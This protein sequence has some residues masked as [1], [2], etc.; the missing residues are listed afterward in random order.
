MILEFKSYNQDET[1]TPKKSSFTFITGI[2]LIQA[3]L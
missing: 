1:I 3:G 2:L